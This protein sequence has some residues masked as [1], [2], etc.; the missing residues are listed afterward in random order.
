MQGL[1]RIY[2]RLKEIVDDPSVE[3][4]PNSS[5]VWRAFLD[6]IGVF[7]M[8][9][10][11]SHY[12]YLKEEKLDSSNLTVESL[13][14]LAVENLER[15]LAGR[16]EIHDLSDGVTM[17]AGLE[18]LE[19]SLVFL[20]HKLAEFGFRGS[21]DCLG[22]PARDVLLFGR[23][24]DGKAVHRIRFAMRNVLDGLP[25]SQR[26]SDR[27]IV[28]DQSSP[29]GYSHLEWDFDCQPASSTF[30]SRSFWPFARH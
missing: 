12:E 30:S 7:Y 5:L 17:V 20:P 28:A 16:G 19:T 11:G 4:R 26:V 8:N 2:P 21:E 15:F 22:L 10:C 18:G 24:S 14:D 13:H 3:E 29:S 9:D 23:R 6:D 25:P 27:M 1:D